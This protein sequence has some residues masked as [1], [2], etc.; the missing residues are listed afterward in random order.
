M[1]D[2]PPSMGSDLMDDIQVG[3]SLPVMYV[4]VAAGLERLDGTVDGGL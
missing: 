1:G 3:G 2:D 4:E